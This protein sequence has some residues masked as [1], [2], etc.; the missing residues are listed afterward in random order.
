MSRLPEHQCHR[1][2]ALDY[3]DTL[4][5]CLPLIISPATHLMPVSTMTFQ[6]D[7]S[8]SLISQDV[9]NIG[10]TKTQRATG[11]RF[12]YRVCKNR[13]YKELAILKTTPS[14]RGLALS[15]MG[16]MP[17]KMP[18]THFWVFG[19]RARLW[20]PIPTSCKH[21]PWETA[22]DG[23]GSWVP[24]NHVGTQT[25]Y[26]QL[27]FPAQLQWLQGSVDWTSRPKHTLSLLLSFFAFFFLCVCLNKELTSI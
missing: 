23:S 17:M 9:E 20:L 7:S 18:A 16:K 12:Q 2:H 24:A 14:G 19:F 27:W 11:W 4:L 21:G 25:R 10:R 15:I 5:I 13:Q 22:G 26:L 8:A 6:N 3:N 1:P